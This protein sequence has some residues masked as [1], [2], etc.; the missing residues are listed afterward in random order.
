MFRE[1]QKAEPFKSDR[2]IIGFVL[3]MA[4]FVW[5]IVSFLIEFNQACDFSW[6]SASG[7]VMVTGTILF[8]RLKPGSGLDGGMNLGSLPRHG[9]PKR[10]FDEWLIKNGGRVSIF[11]L[12]L[13]TL[14][15]AYGEKL[16]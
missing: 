8:E 14:I 15:W 13:G 4:S 6:F 9:Q 1:K 10:K 11:T 3:M 5:A 2:M 16:L 7:A 12:I